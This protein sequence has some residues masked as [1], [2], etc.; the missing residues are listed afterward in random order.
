MDQA[1]LAAMFAEGRPDQSQLAAEFEQAAPIAP[2]QGVPQDRTVLQELGRQ[3]G[4]TGRAAF[5]GITAPANMIGDA[6]GLNSS[7]GVRDMLTKIG[8]PK[9]ETDIERVSNAVVQA[10]SSMAVPVGVGS[11]MAQSAP[12][13][14]RNIGQVLASQPGQQGAYAGVAGGAAQLTAEGGGDQFDQMAAGLLAAP[15]L[16]M[17]LKA[18]APVARQIGHVA[19]SAF[20]KDG[21]KRAA[22][23]VAVDVSKD[24]AGAVTRALREG[25]PVE[26]A[27]G[28]A[29]PAGSAEFAGLEQMVAARRPSV[30]GPDGTVA[31]SQAQYIDDMW[32]DLNNATRQLREAELSGANVAGDIGDSLRQQIAQKKASLAAALQTSGRA[33]TESAQQG[34]LA[35]RP[36]VPVAGQPRISSR[37]SH[38]TDRV[39]EWQSAADDAANIAGQRRTEAGLKQF[40]LDSI[41]A[42][43]MKP[44]TVDSII[45]QINT[46]LNT[47]GLRASDTAQAVLGS[48]RDK[49]ASVVGDNGVIDSRDLYTIR[50]EMGNKIKMLSRQEGWDKAMTE[51]LVKDVQKSIDDA[52]GSA[53]GSIR[54]DGTSDWTDYLK[55]YS[56]GAKRIEGITERA[57]TANRMGNA[58]RQEAQR[59]FN[60]EEVPI[61]LPNLLSRPIMVANAII[62]FMEGKGGQKTVNELSRLMQPQNKEELAALMQAELA[63]RVPAQRTSSVLQ[64]A[65]GAGAMGGM[66]GE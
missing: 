57:E 30:F 18:G 39:P 51:G 6:V 61:T 5:E 53:S 32:K 35:D 26:T 65:A 10:G 7:A 46:R 45:G 49:I 11:M 36:F 50:K 52:I 28:A 3:L 20:A 41:A 2:Q 31:K 48:F 15:T 40:Q 24:Q 14:V 54:R 56:E 59:V 12:G 34:V 63:R 8:L 44:L 9:P 33:A 58:G 13:A 22:G 27:A 17:A 29:A 19:D 47:P 1:T 38:N 21:P 66:A 37:H 16:A 60:A 62:R 42:Y 23:R 4:L 64:R 25:E 55:K 43:G